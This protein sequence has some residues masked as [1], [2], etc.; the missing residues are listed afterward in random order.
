MFCEQAS[1]RADKVPAADKYQNLIDWKTMPTS[2]NIKFYTDKRNMIAEEIIHKSKFPEKSS[3]GPA[4]Y[5]HYDSWKYQQKS[6]KGNCKNKE[7][8]IT[9]VA[10][11]SWHGE[12]S[13]PAKYPSIDVVSRR[14]T[15][16]LFINRF[17]SSFTW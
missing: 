9:F 16:Y 6:P 8:R 5:D 11:Q 17:S 7:D 13:P 15:G 14:S 2:R 12:Q 1:K 3:P 10:E 4:A